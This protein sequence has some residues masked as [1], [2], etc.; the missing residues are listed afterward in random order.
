MIATLFGLANAGRTNAKGMPGPLQLALTGGREFSDVIR[1]TSPP[2]AV[3]SVAFTL[4]GA[5]G[6]VRG[7]SG[8]YPEY[9]APHGRTEPD[10]DVVALAGLTPG[11]AGAR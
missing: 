8:S 10:A 11:G 5:L 6:R 4:L 3:Q 1:F 2:P 9:L 7:L